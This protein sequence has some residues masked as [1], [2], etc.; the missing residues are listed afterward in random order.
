M[1]SYDNMRM[2][3]V[4]VSGIVFIY[5]AYGVP[6]IIRIRTCV[7]ILPNAGVTST[8]KMYWKHWLRREYPLEWPLLN[9]SWKRYKFSFPGRNTKMYCIPTGT[10]VVQECNRSC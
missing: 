3:E 10:R 1:K 4:I 8:M 6:V 7:T 5:I 9:W 2:L